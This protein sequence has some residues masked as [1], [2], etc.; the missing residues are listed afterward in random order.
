MHLGIFF[1]ERGMGPEQKAKEAAA[2]VVVVGVV[3]RSPVVV[4]VHHAVCGV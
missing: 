4:W 3:S 1:R 2:V